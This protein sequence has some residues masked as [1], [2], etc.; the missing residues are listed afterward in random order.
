MTEP[1]AGIVPSAQLKSGPAPIGAQLPCDGLSAPWLK[2]L[3]QTA[4]NP[5]VVASDGPAL[6][7]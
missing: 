1:P 3:G 7:T 2:P 6:V 4:L 5:T